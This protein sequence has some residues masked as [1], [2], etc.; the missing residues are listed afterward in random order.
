ML[1][2]LAPGLGFG[3]LVGKPIDLLFT[4]VSKDKRK[5]FDKA[6]IKIRVHYF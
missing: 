5:S 1:F 3:N 4:V 6:D 2:D